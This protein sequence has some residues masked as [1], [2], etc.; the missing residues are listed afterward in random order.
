MR[1]DQ[2][3]KLDFKAA[4][5]RAD[6]CKPRLFR[7]SFLFWGLGGGACLT[8]SS[9][10]S[11]TMLTAVKRAGGSCVDERLRTLA[12]AW[13]PWATR[14]SAATTRVRRAISA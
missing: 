10:S 13:K 9:T 4:L 5:E 7:T 6:V 1:I 8:L 3:V 11:A 14:A 12:G 2:D